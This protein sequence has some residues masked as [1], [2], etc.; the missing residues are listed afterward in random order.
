M[1]EKNLEKPTYLLHHFETDN[2]HLIDLKWRVSGFL[3]VMELIIPPFILSKIFHQL[4]VLIGIF[5]GKNDAYKNCLE[6]ITLIP[7]LFGTL[8]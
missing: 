7:N 4:D 2:S 1:W 8:E 5:K 6:K 3:F